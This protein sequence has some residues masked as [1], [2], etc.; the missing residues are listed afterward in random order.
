MDDFEQSFKPQDSFMEL[1]DYALKV[2]D[3]RD[4]MLEDEF[5][6][7]WKINQQRGNS[8]S[9]FIH[10]SPDWQKRIT[11]KIDEDKERHEWFAEI[12]E[13]LFE[14]PMDNAG[15]GI[16]V[17]Q[18]YGQKCAEFVRIQDNQTWQ[19][20]LT[21]TSPII[22]YSVQKCRITLHNFDGA[23]TDKLDVRIVPSQSSLPINTQTV[24][25]GK[26]DEV[27]EMVMSK[28]W[29]N[30]AA[31]LGKIDMENSGNSNPTNN[32]SSA[33]YEGLKTK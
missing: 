21:A 25:D 4:A 10:V 22:L 1:I 24:P 16:Q 20:C 12:C 33:V 23:C 27:K 30:Y 5:L 6:V 29:R 19:I 13:P 9:N 3:A 8:Y 15:M 14:F 31:R 28:I 11:V 17:V 2:V 26:A 7:Q 32:E 18:P